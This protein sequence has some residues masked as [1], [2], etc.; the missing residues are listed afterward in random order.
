VTLPCETRVFK[1]PGAV[2]LVF[3]ALSRAPGNL[4]WTRNFAYNFPLEKKKKK[5]KEK[6]Q[7]TAKVGNGKSMV[8]LEYQRE[9]DELDIKTNRGKWLRQSHRLL[10][11]HTWLKSSPTS[12]RHPSLSPFFSFLAHLPMKTS[13]SET[14]LF[15][16]LY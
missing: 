13:V 14:K 7:E 2:L 5:R 8:L 3:H 4:D 11:E 12:Q 10:P 6:K 9:I 1:T 15:L 16:F